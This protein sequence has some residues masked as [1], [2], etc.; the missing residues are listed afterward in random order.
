MHAMSWIFTL[1][2]TTGK[3]T[4]LILNSPQCS[5]T[6]CQSP[7]VEAG[8]DV[9]CY[10]FHIIPFH[11]Q[12][13]SK[14]KKSKVLMNFW[15]LDVDLRYITGQLDC[16]YFF[17]VLFLTLFALPMPNLEITELPEPLDGMHKIITIRNNMFL[18]INA[19]LM[20]SACFVLQRWKK[21]IFFF[22]PSCSIC[23]VCICFL[24]DTRCR[25]ATAFF[26]NIH[27]YIDRGKK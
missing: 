21:K 5:Q 20:E 10:Q 11:F 8:S 3:D 17:H 7:A 14:R 4:H 1:W 16:A 22:L 18:F 19:I 24:D 2:N 25:S 23:P 12:E 9:C 13:V 27:T 15:S 26:I 6:R